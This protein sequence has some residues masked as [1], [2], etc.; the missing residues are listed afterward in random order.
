MKI[1][2]QVILTPSTS[3]PTTNQLPLFLFRCSQFLQHW[4]HE[5]YVT[6]SLRHCTHYDCFVCTPPN[7]V[8]VLWQCGITNYRTN[9]AKHF[10]NNIFQGI[11]KQNEYMLFV[12]GG[13]IL[14]QIFCVQHMPGLVLQYF[15]LQW[16][17]NSLWLHLGACLSWQLMWQAFSWSCLY[18][19]LVLRFALVSP[20]YWG[21][22]QDY[23]PWDY[24][25]M[26]YC[27]WTWEDIT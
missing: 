19:G 8:Q 4:W 2:H 20:C 1:S 17:G 13:Q 7:I 18:C 21:Y 5:G 15:S 23:K 24:F 16:I 25:G 9:N 10:L 22:S 3:S 26:M 14:L 27:V 11:W 6:E 12:K